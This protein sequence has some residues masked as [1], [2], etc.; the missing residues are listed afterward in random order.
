MSSG[1]SVHDSATASWILKLRDD[2]LEKSARRF[3]AS[4]DQLL[5]DDSVYALAIIRGRNFVRDATRR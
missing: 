2:V 5:E 4:I 1:I 3:E